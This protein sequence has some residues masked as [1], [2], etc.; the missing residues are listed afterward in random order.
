M[1]VEEVQYLPIKSKLNNSN[2]QPS[3]STKYTKLRS[4]FRKANTFLGT[5]SLFF[6]S[7]LWITPAIK[8]I[9]QIY[10]K[11]N[12]DIVVSTF[13]PPAA[14]IIGHYVKKRHKEIFW[15]ADYRDLWSDGHLFESKGIFSRLERYIEKKYTASC[16][17]LT[18]VSEPLKLTLENKLG[19]PTFVIENGFDIDEYSLKS[20]SANLKTSKVRMVYTGTVLEKQNPLSL[21]EAL[22]EL[23]KQQKNIDKKIEVIFYS[24]SFQYI[25]SLIERFRVS[26]IVTIKPYLPRKEILNI[27]KEADALIFL[28]WNDPKVS[29]ILTNKIFEYMYSG[30]LI[31]AIGSDKRTIAS[32][33][34]EEVGVGVYLGN[35]VSSIKDVIKKMLNAEQ[36]S[37]SPNPEILKKY[38]REA[39][40]AK[41]IQLIIQRADSNKNNQ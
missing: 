10:K 12:F 22:S 26:K 14:H 40:A 16:D 36:L 6:A 4:F 8:K 28:D 32:D 25:N 31:L 1:W 38:T 29:G 37:Y 2:H 3:S 41:L 13:G 21:F 17:L 23:S 18:V 9:S 35:S 39:L 19:K 15:V 27:Q 30:T 7:M 24:L 34:I 5:G 33:L 11:N 20:M